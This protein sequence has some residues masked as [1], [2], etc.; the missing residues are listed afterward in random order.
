MC[1]CVHERVSAAHSGRLTDDYRKYTGTADLVATSAK[2]L[3]TAQ[4][5]SSSSNS[6]RAATAQLFAERKKESTDRA[7][8]THTHKQTIL[9]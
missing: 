2:S 4:P 1:V 9:I 7:T 8:H 5:I 6:G 3:E